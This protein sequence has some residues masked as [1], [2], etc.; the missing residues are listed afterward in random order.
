[1]IR[2]VVRTILL[3]L[4]SYIIIHQ[5]QGRA[6]NSHNLA[7]LY[8]GTVLVE[9]IVQSTDTSIFGVLREMSDDS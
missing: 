7:Y 9:L 2:H 6:A 5:I 4:L 1:M 8:Y 3:T